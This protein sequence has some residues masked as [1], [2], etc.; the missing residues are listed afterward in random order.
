MKLEEN[1]VN[2]PV[3][4]NTINIVCFSSV[5]VIVILNDLPENGYPDLSTDE[6]DIP[7]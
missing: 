6:S 7:I 4:Y 2:S 1:N 5:H 3:N